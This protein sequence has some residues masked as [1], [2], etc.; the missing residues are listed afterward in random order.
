MT[1]TTPQP[2]VT[3][4]GLAGV[5]VADTA[6]GDVRGD[7]GFFHY[8]QYDALDLARHVTFEEVW[9]LMV[10]G[11]LPDAAQA[12]A[13]AAEVAAAAEPAE[14]VRRELT[15]VLRRVRAAIGPDLPLTASL[16]P[17]ANVTDAMVRHADALVPYRTYPHVDMK[18]TGARATRLLLERIRRGRP[19]AK[20]FRQV[21][22]LI[23]LSMQC[24]CLLYT[25]P[26][27]RD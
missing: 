14:D 2:I 13:W 15:E 16:D 19:W 4:P 7:D 26:S 20:A 22:F 5:V 27:P 21:D 12:P 25:S 6:V 9:H 17:H 10:R 3:P 23:P 8:R 11:A 18:E 24:T 1:T